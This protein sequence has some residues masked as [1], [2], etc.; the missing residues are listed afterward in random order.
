MMLDVLRATKVVPAFR[1]AIVLHMVEVSPALERVQRQALIATDVPVSWHPSLEDVPDGPLIILANEFVD[2]LPIHQ[3]VM[4]ADGWHERVVKLR[5]D[6][7]L[8]FSID[9]DPMPLFEE[10]LPR[11]FARLQRSARFSSGAATSSRLRS[12]GGWRNRGALH[13]LLIM[14]TSSRRSGKRCRR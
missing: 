2:A 11:P 10:F 8:H 14:G 12:D 7:R 9:R 13:S 3:A 4:C 6:S 1:A 5:D